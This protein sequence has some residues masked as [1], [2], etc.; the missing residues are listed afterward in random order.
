MSDYKGVFPRRATGASRF[1]LER[2][3][4]AGER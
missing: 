4:C 1:V 3:P 2:G